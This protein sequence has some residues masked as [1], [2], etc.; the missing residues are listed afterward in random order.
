MLPCL[1]QGVELPLSAVF[2]SKYTTSGSV[3][4]DYDQITVALGF[5]S[6]VAV[7]ESGTMILAWNTFDIFSFKIRVNAALFAGTVA[8]SEGPLQLGVRS[9]YTPSA[10]VDTGNTLLNTGIDIAYDSEG[11]F[12]VTWGGSNLFSNH[13]YL[14]EIDSTG[15]YLSNELQVSQGAGVNYAPSIATDSQGNIIIVWNKVS[16][17]QLFTSFSAVYARRYDNNLQALGDEF[18]VNLSY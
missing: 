4:E 13:V 11:D 1:S 8:P 18:K 10:F 16:P 6:S 12:F 7:N 9:A 17:A 15:G 14:K 3:L 5:N 2:Y